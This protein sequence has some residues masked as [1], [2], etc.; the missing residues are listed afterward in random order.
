MQSTKIFQGWNTQGDKLQQHFAVTD[1]SLSTRSLQQHIATTCHIDKLLCVY[2]RILT[3][4]FVSTS[5]FYHCN[6]LHKTKLV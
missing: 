6:K 4:I 1:H 5:E 2:Q 3:K